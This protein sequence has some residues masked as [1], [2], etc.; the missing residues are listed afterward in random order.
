MYTSLISPALTFQYTKKNLPEPVLGLHQLEA[1]YAYR[2][3]GYT[4]TSNGLQAPASGSAQ[5]YSTGATTGGII[6]TGGGTLLNA[7]LTGYG[8]LELFQ[9]EIDGSGTATFLD[10]ND[11]GNAGEFYF[12]G[13]SIIGI[14]L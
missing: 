14:D 7:S 5:I 6:Y 4:T 12:V 8:R 3:D 9:M 11:N 10:M 2:L 1:G 13:C